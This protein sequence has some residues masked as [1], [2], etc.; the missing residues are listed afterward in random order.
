M[1]RFPWAIATMVA[2]LLPLVGCNT[3]KES[4]TSPTV[5]PAS[6]STSTEKAGTTKEPVTGGTDSTKNFGKLTSIVSATKTAVEAGNFEQ[7][8][9]A[10]AGFEEGWQPIEDGVKAKSPSAY[11]AI[12]D[13]KDL[14]EGA[15]KA[16]D[17]AKALEALQA[18][19]KNIALAQ[20]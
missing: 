17:K 14:L 11:S 18:L 6:S 8:K 12:E 4:T 15:I 7:A 16:K 1:T 9:T 5:D 2:I 20:S 13:N 3:A 19:S 10:I